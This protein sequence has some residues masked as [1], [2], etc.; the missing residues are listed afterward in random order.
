MAGAP[1]ELPEELNIADYFLDRH[2]REGRGDRVAIR[3]K[4][5]EATYAEVRDRA[6]AWARTLAA[7]GLRREE[8]VLLALPDSAEWVALFFGILEVGA[9]VVMLNP[10]LSEDE[11][12]AR[13]DYVRPRMAIVD[14][15]RIERYDNAAR[16]F[17]WLEDGLVVLEDGVDEA[18]PAIAIPVPTHRDDPAIWLFS[19]G[20]TGRPKA[21]VQTHRSFVNTTELYAVR[22]LGYGPDDITLSVPKLFFGY[23]TGSNLLFPFAVGAST[24]LFP[25]K[26]TPEVLFEQIARH[27][28][29]I[30]INVPT[31]IGRMVTHPDAAAH[32]LSCLRIVT[33]AG[34]AL[35]I[36]LHERWRETFGVDLLDG[37]GTAEMWHVFLTNRPGDV[38]PGTLGRA[39]EGFTIDVR[40]ADGHTVPVDEIGRLWVRG[41]S[42]AIG[43]WQNIDQS[44]AAFRGEWFVGGDLVRRDADGYV[45]Y[46]GRGDDA[47][48]VAGR[49]LVPKE[50]EDCLM[51]HPRVI[52]CAVVGADLG[53]GL[54]KPIAFVRPSE[55]ES[56]GDDLVDELKTWT[57]D[58]LDAYKHPRRITLV[59]DFARTHL[60][61][62]DR[63]ALRRLATG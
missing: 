30:L 26:P 54:T 32:D 56:E 47:L 36:A 31:V 43:Y 7:R 50:V 10:D 51:R 63:G 37:L 14:R 3:A 24:V 5:G 42:R 17:P 19:G 61:K 34:E 48:K 25:E 9:V 12:A 35:P 38:R 60:G 15:E 41:D 11:V 8:R 46:A 29:T 58:C 21:V 13:I 39:V 40:D 4:S 27:R 22:T 44:A 33:S 55:G 53:D 52:E 20:T 45:T 62:I 59:E 23:A 49:W 28:P 18:A 16:P 2:L 6:H 57:L 1:V